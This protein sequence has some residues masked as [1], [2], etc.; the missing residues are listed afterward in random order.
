VRGLE[1][2]SP[3]SIKSY[4]SPGVRVHMQTQHGGRM[5]NSPSKEE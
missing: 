5:M 4:M 1:G 3:C 2:G